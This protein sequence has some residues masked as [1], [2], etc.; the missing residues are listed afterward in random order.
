MSITVLIEVFNEE[1]NIVDCIKSA[2]LLTQT[3]I[4]VDMQSTDHT[5]EIAKKMGAT[6]I[7]FDA[8]PLYVEPAREFGIR[9]IKTDWVMIL[10]ADERMTKELADEILYVIASEAKQSKDDKTTYYKIPAKISLGKKPACRQAGGYNTE[11][12]GRMNR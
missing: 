1:K 4:V 12:G 6:V 9:Q 10:G 5:V 2:Q 7:P 8:H 11:V 3:V